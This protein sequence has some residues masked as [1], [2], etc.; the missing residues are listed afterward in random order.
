MKEKMDGYFSVFNSHVNNA[1]KRAKVAFQKKFGP[2]AWKSSGMASAERDG[3]MVIFREKP[4][5]FTKFY[6]DKVEEFV[7][8]E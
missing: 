3:I 5:K 4:T 6:V 2:S 1:H 7:N 8:E